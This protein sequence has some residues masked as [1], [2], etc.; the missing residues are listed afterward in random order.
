MG[1]ARD[2][3][4]VAMVLGLLAAAVWFLR[5]TGAALPRPFRLPAARKARK[6]EAIERVALTP[7]HALHLVRFGQREMIVSTHPQGCTVLAGDGQAGPGTG[8]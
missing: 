4:A 2:L 5:R 1:I 8:A 7:Q 3:G 6:L